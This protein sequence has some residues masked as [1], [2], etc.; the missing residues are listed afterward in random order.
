MCWPRSYSGSLAIAISFPLQDLAVSLQQLSQHGHSISEQSVAKAR[1]PG[2]RLM[3]TQRLPVLPDR[4]F[5]SR[6]KYAGDKRGLC[7]CNAKLLKTL[8][9][10][11]YLGSASSL[12]MKECFRSTYCC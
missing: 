5:L 11:A 4:S 7:E 10:R 3:S 8:A 1:R 12:S 6:Y 9:T 2:R